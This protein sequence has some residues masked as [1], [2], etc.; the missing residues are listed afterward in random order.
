[1]A[2]KVVAGD[3]EPLNIQPDKVE[4]NCPRCKATE[5]TSHARTIR[6]QAG[7]LVFCAKCGAILGWGPK[8]N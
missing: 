6:G 1:M 2:R 4:P 7:V 8:L 3:Y 5:F